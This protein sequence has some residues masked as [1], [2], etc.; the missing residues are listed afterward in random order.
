MVQ[1]SLDYQGAALLQDFL[2]QQ[3][4]S[5]NQKLENVQTQGCSKHT[6]DDVK[7][8]EMDAHDLGWAQLAQ[9]IRAVYKSK[10]VQPCTTCAHIAV[11]DNL[12]TETLSGTRILST[13]SCTQMGA[14]HASL[15]GWV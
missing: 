9:Q 1:E 15:H 3:M 6:L 4:D 10:R 7:R 2:Q 14:A 13:T 12:T 8:F 5:L 11:E